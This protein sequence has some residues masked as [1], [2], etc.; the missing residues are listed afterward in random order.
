LP[1]KDQEIL[2]LV[3]WEG[4]SRD[5]VGD[6]F[7]VSRAAID[8]RISRAYKKIARELGIPSQ[9][10]LTTPVPAEEGGEA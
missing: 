7:Y 8:K 6:M 4:L 5:Q 2:R 1:E 9:G 10:A 3:E